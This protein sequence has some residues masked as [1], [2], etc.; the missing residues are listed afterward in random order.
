MCRHG[1]CWYCIIHNHFWFHLQCLNLTKLRWNSVS[2]DEAISKFRESFL[3][4]VNLSFEVRWS[5]YP[6]QQLQCNCHTHILLLLVSFGNK[7]YLDTGDILC[8][9]WSW[10]M[11]AEKSSL[12]TFYQFHALY[13]LTCWMLGEPRLSFSPYFHLYHHLPHH[14]QHPSPLLQL[15]FPGGRQPGDWGHKVCP[16][17]L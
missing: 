9:R 14:L 11:W 5:Q 17:P 12:T 6:L 7:S 8:K 2:E 16:R 1:Y 15:Y 10:A 4:K 13:H 3:N